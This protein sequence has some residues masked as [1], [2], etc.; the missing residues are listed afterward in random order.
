[1]NYKK[2]LRDL[3]LRI[4]ND[5]FSFNFDIDVIEKSKTELN[6]I[7][8]NF[9]NDIISGS[10]ALYLYGLIKHRKI[11]DFD[12]IIKDKERYT[13][14]IKLEGY[15]G[16]LEIDNRLGYIS[17]YHKNKNVLDFVPYASVFKKR[18]HYEVDFF[19][20][21]IENTY[22]ILEYNGKKLK[23]HNPI[24][25]ISHKMGM[26]SFKHSRDLLLIFRNINNEFFPFLK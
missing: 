9:E 2:E 15:G 16:D 5:E 4:I 12:I 13:N 14:Y 17:F 20:E 19:E 3:K 21:I 10:F 1:M 25:I 7:S 18:Y 8:D 11:G 26:D 23:I 22:D 6:F 24:E